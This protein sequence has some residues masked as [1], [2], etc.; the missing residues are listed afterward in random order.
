LIRAPPASDD[1]ATL[2]EEAVLTEKFSVGDIVLF[3]Y[4]GRMRKGTV[5]E[6]YGIPG[7]VKVV[8]NMTPELTGIGVMEPTTIVF[9][10]ERIELVQV[11]G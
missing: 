2:G 7:R 10:I 6:I 11:V 5:R 8:I 4:V 3:P 9:P 1:W